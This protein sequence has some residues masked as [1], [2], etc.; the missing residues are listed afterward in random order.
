MSTPAEILNTEIKKFPGPFTFTIARGRAEF[1]YTLRV[2]VG[3]GLK[4]VG[5]GPGRVLKSGPDS[6]SG[7]NSC[8]NA[9]RSIYSMH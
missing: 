9:A 3:F 5:F 2:R 8:C 1:L 4:I 7:M 6:N